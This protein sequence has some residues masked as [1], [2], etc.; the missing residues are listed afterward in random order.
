MDLPEY[1]QIGMAVSDQIRTIEFTANN[2]GK[3]P[4]KG[5]QMCGYSHETLLGDVNVY[6]PYKFRNW[7]NEQ[8]KKD[9]NY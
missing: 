1:R 5:H 9:T 3:Y 4:L 8:S 6:S 2:T 7:R